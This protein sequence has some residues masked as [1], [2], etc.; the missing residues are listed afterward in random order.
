VL[1]EER[2]ELGTSWLVD[3]ILGERRWK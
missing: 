2:L 1:V 3:D